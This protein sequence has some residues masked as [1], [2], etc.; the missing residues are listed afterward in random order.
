MTTKAHEQL[1]KKL[2]QDV[3]EFLKKGGVIMTVAPGVSTTSE[4][5]DKIEKTLS[6]LAFTRKNRTNVFAIYDME[7]YLAGRS[8]DKED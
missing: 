1:R 5:V 8:H 3:E 4:V 2:Q 7:Q 6:G